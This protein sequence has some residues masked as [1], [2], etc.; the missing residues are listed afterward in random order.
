LLI[1]QDEKKSDPVAW[2]M[3]FCGWNSEFY[4]FLSAGDEIIVNISFI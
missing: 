4:P 3:S 1:I 2:E